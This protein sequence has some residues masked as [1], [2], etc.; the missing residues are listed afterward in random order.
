MADKNKD[1]NTNYLSQKVGEDSK[2][3]F[4]KLSNDLGSFAISNG[5]PE[6]SKGEV[7]SKLINDGVSQYGGKNLE[8]YFKK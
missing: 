1:G 6:P 5:F 8:R 4:N 3:S 2:N 7:L